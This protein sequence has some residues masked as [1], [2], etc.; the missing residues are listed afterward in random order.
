[1]T[2]RHG[3]FACSLSLLE[4]LKRQAHARWNDVVAGFFKV[5]LQ[6]A[7]PSR[8]EPRIPPSPRKGKGQARVRVG[9]CGFSQILRMGTAAALRKGPASI[10]L[11]SSLGAGRWWEWWGFDLACQKLTFHQRSKAAG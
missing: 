4:V 1:M 10:A 5:R 11:H 9:G 2:G 3:R 6:V 8:T 7:M